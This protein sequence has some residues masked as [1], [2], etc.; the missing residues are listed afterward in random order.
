LIKIGLVGVQI[1]LFAAVVSQ[2]LRWWRASGNQRWLMA[3]AIICTVFLIVADTQGAPGSLSW[4]WVVS[5]TALPAAAVIAIT[6]Y[7]LYDIDLLIHRSVLHALLAVLLIALYAGVVLVGSESFPDWGVA[8]HAVGI[9]AT[10]LAVAPGAPE[11]AG[12]LVV[13]GPR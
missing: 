11:P 7:G 1:S 13:R 12:P 4:A 9:V 10:V 8:V 2:L 3:W 6:R 5:A